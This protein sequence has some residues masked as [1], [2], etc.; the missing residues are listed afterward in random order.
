MRAVNHFLRTKEI[1]QLACLFRSRSL[2]LTVPDAYSLTKRRHESYTTRAHIILRLRSHEF[3]NQF[4]Y[5]WEISRN[6]SNCSSSDD[7]L[8]PLGFVSRNPII[9]ATNL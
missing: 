6:L 8:A 3:E 5:R 9:Y 7:L 1:L 2:R 4:C